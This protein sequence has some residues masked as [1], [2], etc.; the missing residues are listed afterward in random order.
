MYESSILCGF[1]ADDEPVDCCF[2]TGGATIGRLEVVGVVVFGFALGSAD[3][4]L[5]RT[6]AGTCKI[7]IFRSRF[8]G[9]T[10]ILYTIMQ[11]RVEN[12]FIYQKISQIKWT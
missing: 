11:S 5:T 2:A 7:T 8:R 3:S 6:D 1:A 12:V 9:T 4:L 10:D